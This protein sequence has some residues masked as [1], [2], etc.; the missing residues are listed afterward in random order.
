[1][2]T[3]LAF[4]L[5][6]AVG[7]QAAGATKLN[8]PP[9]PRERES[10]SFDNPD[11]E[12][13]ISQPSRFKRR[14][15]YREVEEQ[16]KKDAEEAAAKAEKEKA[17]AIEDRKRANAEA[18]EN[19]KKRQEM[20]IDANNKAVALGKQGRWL[21]AI[22]AH[23]QAVQ[24]DPTSKAFQINLSA[25]R[26]EFGK[27]KL[28]GGDL[29]AAAGLF[30][31]ALAAASDNGLA[32]R[33]LSETMSK[34]G[35]D[36]MS[37]DI[38]IATGDQLAA[39]GDW[40]GASVEYQAAMQLEPSARTYTKMGD[41]ALRF[42]QLGTSV[43]W[44]RQAIIKNPDYGPAHRQLGMVALAQKDYTAA[45][46]S[47][48]K[49]VILDPHDNA[50]GQTLVEIWRKQVA[51]NPLLAENHLGLAGAFQLTGDFVGADSEY[52][53][54]AALDPKNPGLESGRASLARA[55]QHEKAE[56]HRLAAE[57]LFK[58]S[59]RREALAE[60]SQAVMVEPRNAKYQF[61]LGECLEANGDYQGA[62]Q[63]YLTCVLIDPEANQEAAARM[64][65]MQ[66]SSPGPGAAGSPGFGGTGGSPSGYGFQAPPRP[67]AP[68]PQNTVEAAPQLSPM[69]KKDMFEAPPGAFSPGDQ[70]R[71]P[72][73]PAAAAQRAPAAPGGGAPDAGADVTQSDSRISQAEAQRDY[74]TAIAILRELASTHLR[75][76]NVHHRLAVNLL[77]SGDIDEAVAEFRIASA[78]SPSKKEFADDLARAMMIHKR[79]L[80]DQGA[81]QPS[82]KAGATR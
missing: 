75:D 21:E 22:S 58:Q 46:A 32:G 38:R 5:A 64:R 31:K 47:L 82:H 19:Y 76:A 71:A 59:L 9:L 35:R 42:G 78:L 57:T 29:T 68:P 30:R 1:M 79:A 40:Q 43:N 13:I 63:A 53:K 81:R 56:K 54:L 11:S 33:L 67:P 2:A 34:Q 66:S 3:G 14:P 62:H 24:L 73:P 74:P 80:S 69:P 4:G 72:P 60:I 23:E 65:R 10:K 15:D 25:A 51:A 6:L 26:V 28:A 18:I 7:I 12:T 44:Y 49:A 39:I 27:T 55:Y 45:A 8:A 77:S 48:R 20:A 41:M 16:K 37:S 61:L 17:Q 52:R 36:P 50:A 70:E